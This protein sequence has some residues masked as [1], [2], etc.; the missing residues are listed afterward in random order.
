MA[1]KGSWCFEAQVGAGAKTVG[2]IFV[3]QTRDTGRNG[4]SHAPGHGRRK[5]LPLLRS[6]LRRLLLS[7]F[8]L[9]HGAQSPPFWF[10]Q[11][12]GSVKIE[13]TLFSGGECFFCDEARARKL[14]HEDTKSTKEEKKAE[15][16]VQSE[17]ARRT[18]QHA[19]RASS[20]SCSSCLRG[21]ISLI[22]EQHVRL[23]RCRRVG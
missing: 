22:I 20:D 1:G 14:N 17:E 11:I 23:R 4:W 21:F 15:L 19:P 8:L 7:G 12:Y 10:G 9:S 3:H 16:K 18:T 5:K 6:L 2:V 13:S